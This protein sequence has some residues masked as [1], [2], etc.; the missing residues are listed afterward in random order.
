MKKILLL[1]LFIAAFLERTTFNLGPNIEL[2]TMAM[3]VSSLYLNKKQSFYLVFAI[4]ALSDLALGNTSIFLFTWSGFL[5]PVL[6]IGS[7]LKNRKGIKKYFTGTILGIYSNIFFYLW[8]NF[9]VWALDAWG[10]YPKTP[11]GL[12][13]SYINGLPFLKTQLISTTIFVPL[14][15]LSVE[16]LFFLSKRIKVLPKLDWNPSS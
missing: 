15:I 16:L 8:T 1:L 7:L 11:S 2:I 3:V 9:G 13:M 5:I 4:I 12:L 14:G 6:F 10:M